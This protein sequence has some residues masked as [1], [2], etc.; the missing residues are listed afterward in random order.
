MG[1]RAT[2]IYLTKS[3][4]KLA[5]ECPTKLYYARESKSY[6]D[7]NQ[8]NDFLQALADGGYQV[9]ELAKFKYHPDPVSAS[10]T[11][12]PLGYD[13]A[14]AQTKARLAAPGRVVVAEA[15]LLNEPYFVRVDILIRDEAART[16]DI[17]EVKS[18]SVDAKT[19]AAGFKGNNGK[20]ASEWLPYLYDVTFQAEVAKRVFPDYEIRPKLLLVDSE[21]VSD[22][23][24]LHQQF[25]IVPL[26]E[27][28]SGR[29]RVSV[30]S[31][32]GL[33]ATDLGRLNL[34]REVDVR[35][36]VAELRSMPLA[37]VAHVPPPQRKDMLTFMEW[38]GRLQMEGGRHFFGVSK[39][40]RAC[41]Y[42]A[43]ADHPLRSGVHE[44]WV[45]AIQMGLLQGGQR[46]VDRNVPLSIDLWGGA[47][48]SKSVADTVLG[49]G[50]AFLADVEGSD[51]QP[52][53]TKS[54][55][56]IS[57]L[58]R[59]M[60]QVR[61]ASGQSQRFELDERRLEAMDKWEWPLHMIDFETSAPALPFFKGMHP[62]ETLAF[63]FSHHTMERQADGFVKVRHA[64]QWIST[65][66]GVFP[67]IDFVRQLRRALMPE[68]QLHGTVFRYHNHENTVLRGLRKL[69]LSADYALV[70]DAEDL[71]SFIDLITKSTGD[72]AKE[73]GEFQG[74]RTMV[75]L[76]RLVQEGYYSCA[77][78]GSI[79]LKYI[80]PAIL[81][82]APQLAAMY[83]RAGFYGK[84]MRVESLNFDEPG[85]HVW[86]QQDKGMDPYKT[87]PPI[88]GPGHGAIDEI[89]QRLAGDDEEDSSINQGGLAMTAYNY[90]QFN[91]L[92]QFERTSI[93]QALLRYCELDTMAMVMLVQ[94]LFELRGMPLRFG[95]I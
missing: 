25:K 39:N 58:E 63:Q 49:H 86:L 84:G 4:F 56:G 93:E 16:I 26:K 18:K 5:L 70:T 43:P 48:G 72:E 69:I 91:S 10:I 8:D 57:P 83:S 50:R 33:K 45:S 62:Y 32:A 35:D 74:P 23:D 85:G 44:C 55:P 87:L 7:K 82:D 31:P 12:E 24:G 11:V 64:H 14:L 94:G 51:I 13:D 77:S 80:L 89:L 90:T 21:Q 65:A 67:S 92:G 59:R 53:K 54:S 28:Q 30:Q 2:K 42:R 1:L 81:H 73:L 38:A 40:C 19:I 61:C 9:G 29:T 36:V 79:S 27:D 22:V 76:H 46:V 41:Q 52:G 95:S 68:G 17:I 20:Y 15:A 78:G 34:L 71:L 3:R 60:A 75:D 66:A 37:N 6:F 88:F 47:F